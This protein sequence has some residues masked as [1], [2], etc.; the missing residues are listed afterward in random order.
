MRFLDNLEK[1]APTASSIQ[2]LL[3]MPSS[4]VDVQMDTIQEDNLSDF[5]DSVMNSAYS[6]SEASQISS[7]PSSARAK[8]YSNVQKQTEIEKKFLN[9][10]DEELSQKKRDTVD[11]YLKQ[12]GDIL[13]RLPYIRRRNLQ[14]KILDIVIEEED[15]IFM[16][17]EN[18]N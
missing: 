11:S 3:E 15:V 6:P 12:L 1:I 10:I 7:C 16:E 13:R 4:H 9:M 14:R 5:D 2:H 18:A 17:R 8:K